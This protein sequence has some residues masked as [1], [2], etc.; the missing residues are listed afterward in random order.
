[1]MLSYKLWHTAKVKLIITFT[2]IHVVPTVGGG[3][4]GRVCV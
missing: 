4:D 1:M 3:G 2:D